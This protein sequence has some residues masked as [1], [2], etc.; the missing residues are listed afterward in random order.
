MLSCLSSFTLTKLRYLDSRGV[1][2]ELETDSTGCDPGGASAHPDAPFV[3]SL[4]RSSGQLPDDD[5]LMGLTARSQKTFQ[6]RES[7]N[8]AVT[9]AQHESW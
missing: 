3:I 9:D 1:D 5:F 4:S 8:D 2:G 7:L 6:K